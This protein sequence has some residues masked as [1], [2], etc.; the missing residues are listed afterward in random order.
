MNEHALGAALRERYPRPENVDLLAGLELRRRRAP[1]ARAVLAAA[2]CVLAVVAVSVVLAVRAADRPAEPA[3][4]KAL[5]GV[6]WQGAQANLTLTFTADTVRIFDGCDSE[7][8]ELAVGRSTLTIGP[9]VGKGS[10]CG[11]PPTGSANLARRFDRVVF[12]RKIT[13][14]RAGDALNL[15][16]R[17][18]TTITLHVVGP[19]LEVPGRSWSLERYNDPR[20]YSR[21]GDFSRSRLRIADGA[22]HASDLCN[23]LTGSA[24]VSD[25]RITISDARWTTRGCT[26]KASTDIHRVLSGPLTYAIR[27]DELMVD[28]GRR[29]LLIYTPAN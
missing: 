13:W 28:G 3:Y 20:G 26:G 21:D 6:T 11:G 17:R 5:T 23:V 27:G 24:T 7:L 16:N 1:R 12:S 14:H 19:A 10:A 25:A 9:L 15:T 18:G 2:A 22:I 8:R 29:G 4:A